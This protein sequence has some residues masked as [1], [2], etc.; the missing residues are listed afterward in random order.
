MDL[1]AITFTELRYLLALA[2]TG[3]FGKAAAKCFVTQPTLSAQLKKLEENLGVQLVERTPRGAQLTPIGQ[4][5]VAHA[6]AILEHVQAIGDAALGHSDPLAGE[7][8]LG[9]IPTLGPYFLPKVLVPLQHTFPR[10]RLFVEEQITA[11]LLEHLLNH[12]LDAALLALPVD[13]SGVEALPLFDEPFW[14]LVPRNH[15]LTKKACIR[16]ADLEGQNVLLLTEGHCLREQALSL[17]MKHN[18]QVAGDFRA[19]SLETLRHLVAA[20]YGCTLIPELAVSSLGDEKTVVRP[21]VGAEARRRIGLVWRKSYPRPESI[22]ALGNFFRTEM[23]RAGLSIPRQG[24]DSES[25]RPDAR[26]A[27]GVKRPSR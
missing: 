27:L 7:L 22:A 5:V 4:Q 1:T 25:D 19:A 12:Q 23:A 6:R 20:G 11:V 18:A 15:P 26:G 8:H 3:H 16:E 24:Q 10:L 2:D 14:V 13:A 17:C 21:L 9:V